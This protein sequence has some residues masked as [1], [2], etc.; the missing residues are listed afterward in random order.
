MTVSP[1]RVGDTYTVN[2]GSNYTQSDQQVSP[3]ETERCTL[4]ISSFIVQCNAFHISHNTTSVCELPIPVISTFLLL[5]V[6]LIDIINP[7][8]VHKILLTYISYCT[9]SNSSSSVACPTQ[10]RSG[11]N[12]FH[13]SVSVS[14]C[15]F[16]VSTAYGSDSGHSFIAH[17]DEVS[18]QSL[19]C[20]YTML[21][22]MRCLHNNPKS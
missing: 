19:I 20:K 17:L 16:I 2:V 3:Q 15:S 9:E 7:L 4:V 18:Q 11:C 5:V 10:P 21:H 13:Y 1:C 22:Y 12:S 8:C 6:L 14:Y